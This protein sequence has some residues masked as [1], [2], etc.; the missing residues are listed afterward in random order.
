MERQ[1]LDIVVERLHAACH[2]A[3]IGIHDFDIEADSIYWDDRVRALWG[4][5]DNMP[6]NYALFASGVH[7]QDLPNVEA[8][9][10]AAFDPTGAGEYLAEY[11]VIN[12]RD[13]SVR[14]I[15]ATGKT[16]FIN[17]KPVRLVGTVRDVTELRQQQNA[18]HAAESLSQSLIAAAPT[19]IYVYSL[20]E[21]RNL[22][23]TPQAASRIG[24]TPEIL[25]KDDGV[26]MQS[27]MHPD[28]QE[29]I[30]QYHAMIAA[31]FRW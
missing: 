1:D 17:G 4:V 16:T 22:F 10:A 31:S 23:I 29:R 14:L 11:R 12:R 30:A 6:I 9:V 3:N 25:M 19:I 8:A 7:P 13:G 24:L 20:I 18:K 27:L 5:D 2:A 26:L 28:D 21:Q 15:S